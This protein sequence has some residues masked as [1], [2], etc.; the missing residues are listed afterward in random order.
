MSQ[1][2]FMTPSSDKDYR[3]LMTKALVELKTTKSKLRT[4]E[5]A[6]TEPIAIIG[7][8][9]RFPGGA[10]NPDAFWQL[11][12]EGRDAIIEVPEERWDIDAYYDP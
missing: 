11:L 5:Q 2:S 9:C 12:R 10:D 3:A 4:L 8:S 1:S 6:K 7:M